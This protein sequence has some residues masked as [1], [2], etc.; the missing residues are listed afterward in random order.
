MRQLVTKIPKQHRVLIVA[1]SVFLSIVL[2]LPS[3]QASASKSSKSDSLEIGKRYSLDVPQSTED[4]TLEQAISELPALPEEDLSLNWS[5][6]QVQKGDAL[7]ALFKKANVSQQVMLDVLALGNSVKTLTRLFPGEQLEF[8]LNEQGELQELRYALNHLTTLRVS[9]NTDGNFVAEELKKEVELR[10]QFA[11]A[12]IRSNFWSAGIEAGLSEAQIM[13]LAGI[14]GWDIDFGLDIRGGD[15]FSVLYETQYVDGEFI[16]NGNIV[17]AQFQN[18]GH[19]YQAVRHTDGNYY[20]PDGASMRQ[21]FLR[22]PVSF[23][24]VS[25]NFNPR[26]LHP[27]LGTVRA[28]NGVDYVAPV[29]TPIMAAGDGRVIASTYN[30]VNGHYVFIQH[31]NNIVTKYLHLSRRDVKQGDRVRQGQAIGRLGAT[32]RVTGAHLH[33]EFVIDGVHRNPRTVKLPQ[34]TPLQGKEKQLFSQQAQQIIAQLATK[35][36][37]LLAKTATDATAAP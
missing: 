4:L 32:G 25:S 12:E 37:V 26:R 30:N 7:S 34:A 22:A 29:G 3:E 5:V 16:S 8:G 1:T 19:V 9:R 17:A 10:S 27:V 35:E 28:H 6:L 11:S 31:A 14:F 13:S 21:A 36:R 20:K 33:Y 18:Q 15:S 23:Q 24:Y 2:L